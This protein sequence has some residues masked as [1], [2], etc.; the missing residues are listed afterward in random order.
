MVLLR[1]LKFVCARNELTKAALS[2]GGEQTGS[3][4]IIINTGAGPNCERK[5]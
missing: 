5:S 1:G 3:F 2:D 4:L